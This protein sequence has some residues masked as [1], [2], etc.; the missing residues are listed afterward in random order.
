MISNFYE[1]QKLVI[2]IRLEF[3]LELGA[4]IYG[5]KLDKPKNFKFANCI[6]I[7]N[8]IRESL[9]AGTLGLESD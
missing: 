2:R 8:F 4:R 3:I 9:K 6:Y 5:F 7:S 1:S